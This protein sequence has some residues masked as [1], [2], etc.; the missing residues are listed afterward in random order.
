[1]TAQSGGA[2]TK[3]AILLWASSP[4]APE[5]CATPFVYAAAAAAMDCEVEIHFTAGSV[6]LL[7]KGVAASLYSS[8]DREKSIFEFMQDAA[9]QGVKFYACSM[10]SREHLRPDEALIGELTGMAGAAA[11]AHRALDPAWT[12]LVF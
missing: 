3:L 1:M 12:T 4:E 9:R 5:L 7:V 10:A 8:S 11:F 2:P 6:R